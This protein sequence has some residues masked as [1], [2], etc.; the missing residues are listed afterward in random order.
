[1]NLR[2]ESRGGWD[3]GGGAM[4]TVGHGCRARRRTENAGGAKGQTVLIGIPDTLHCVRVLV[5][6]RSLLLYSHHMPSH[7][8]MRLQLHVQ[9]LFGKAA[10]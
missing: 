2:R 6:L 5:P 10:E 8:Q 1:M 7:N 9:N 3:E 4:S